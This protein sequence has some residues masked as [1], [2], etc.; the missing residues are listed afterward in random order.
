M[1]NSLIIFSGGMDSATLLVQQKESIKM[2]LGFDYGQKH[3]KELC[4]A[5]S[6][7][8]ELSIPYHIIDL[9]S[10]TPFMKSNLLQNGEA[11]PEG[12]YEDIS[13]KQ[14]VVPFRNGIMLSIAAGIAESNDCDE[15]LI[16]NHAGDHAIY[17]DCR[18]AFI[19]SMRDAVLRGTYKEVLIK[20]PFT[21]KSKRDIALIGRSMQLDF[22]KTWSCYKGGEIHCG[23]C[24]TC[25][26]RKEALHGFDPTIYEA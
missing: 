19:D 20:A 18:S 5:D 9:S 11:V 12:H 26:E 8:Q 1:N 4:Y 6:F 15:I 2:A 10:I 24:G 17:P 23:K 16:A 21:F 25:V 13:M 14:T 7:C 3:K 22:N